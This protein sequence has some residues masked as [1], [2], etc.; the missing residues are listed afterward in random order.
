MKQ[1]LTFWGLMACLP[2]MLTAQTAST[3]IQRNNVKALVR[4]D[5]TMFNHGQ[6]GQFIPVQPGLAEKTLLK[7]SGI[8]LAGFD[9]L[10]NLRGMATVNSQTDCQPGVLD[11]MGTPYDPALVTDIWRVTCADIHQHLSDLTDNGVLDN[12]NLN[13]LRFPA[14]GNPFF[15]GL[16]NGVDLPF[17]QLPFGGFFD[18]DDDGLYDPSRGDYPSIEVR[19]CTL[20]RFPDEQNWW[21]FNSTAAHPSGLGPIALEVQA[22]VLAYKSQN[23][24][25]LENALIVRYKIINRTGTNLDSCYLG[26]FADFEIGN[27]G[28]DYFGSIPGKNIMYAYN[29][30]ANDENGF[31]Q[32][33]PVM[34]VEMFRGALDTFGNELPLQHIMALENA[35]TLQ[36]AEFY[37][38][39]SGRFADGSPAPNN[40]LMFAGNPN[41]PNGNSEQALGNTPGQRAG[42]ASYGPFTLLPG[43]V[44]ELIVAYYY[45]YAPGKTPVETVQPLY[46]NYN[47]VKSMFNGCFYDSDLVCNA[48]VRAPYHISDKKLRLYPNPAATNVVIASEGQ[49]FSRLELCDVLG[50]QIKSI[51]LEKPVQEYVLPVE[52]LAAGVYL[53]KIENVARRIVVQR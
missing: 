27:P 33:I 2:A 16:N 17:T 35:E 6:Q 12:P 53:L 34:A 50:K 8:W 14:K 40:G 25:T 23:P 32:N 18:R 22:Q 41:D 49:L 7:G 3:L 43:A 38:L 30:D 9:S 29:G 47:P 44:N 42:L 52:G 51:D 28:D 10:G 48:T 45:L 5:G 20:D 21:A 15:A 31:G 46:G 36:G 39:L 4:A 24:S 26:L 11:E 1:I 19:G 37:N 13:V